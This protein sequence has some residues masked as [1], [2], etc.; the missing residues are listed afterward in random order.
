MTDTNPSQSNPGG[1][2]QD[3]ETGTSASASASQ[4]VP[5]TPSVKRG[6]GRPRRIVDPNDP[7]MVKRP[8]GRPRG[9]RME[10]AMQVGS[11]L[12]LDLAQTIAYNVRHYLKKH[13]TFMGSEAKLAQACGISVA[14]IGRFL[15]GGSSEITTETLKILAR[16][17]GVTPFDILKPPSLSEL[18]RTSNVSNASLGTKRVPLI[19]YVQ[20]GSWR[21]AIDNYPPGQ[22]SEWLLTDLQLSGNAFALE[23]RGDSMLP[24]F[25]PNDRVIID[26]AVVPQPGDFVVA[27]NAEEGATFK[28][29]RP[30]GIG[31]DGREIIELTP[32]N[33]DYPVMRSDVTPIHIIGTMIE[34][35][36]YRRR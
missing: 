18:R 3:K 30:R 32:L 28:K 9:S 29:Y 20:A 17:L 27:K 26:P 6:P 8:R 36:R 16:G 5:N 31:A 10:H 22:G 19:S 13:P 14:A 33:P 7:L 15:L 25:M 23:I 4:G 1:A 11:D 2:I 12:R 34:H 24:D 21:E 35:R